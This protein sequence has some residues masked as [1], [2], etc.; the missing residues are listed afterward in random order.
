MPG[1]LIVHAV[2]AGDL[3]QGAGMTPAVA[4]AVDTLAAAVL[5]DLRG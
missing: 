2:E 3:G 1:R 4:A 5:R